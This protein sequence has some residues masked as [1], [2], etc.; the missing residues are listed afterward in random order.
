MLYAR[1]WSLF[2]CLTRR[3]Q[4]VAVVTSLLS[5][6]LG[7]PVPRTV[8]MTGELSL[9]GRVLAIGGVQQKIM[10][11]RRAGVSVFILPKANEP[12]VLELAPGLREDVTIHYAETYDDVLRVLFP[13]LLPY[14]VAAVEMESLASHEAASL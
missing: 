14:S 2:T 7:V 1:L 8:A 13:H 12:N 10:A 9:L 4:G 5:L 11:G 3:A 6:A